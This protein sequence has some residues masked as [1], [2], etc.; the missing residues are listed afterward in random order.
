MKN[1]PWG[2]LFLDSPVQAFPGSRYLLHPSITHRTLR[3]LLFSI[4]YLA[5]FEVRGGWRKEPFFDSRTTGVM[6]VLCVLLRYHF[7]PFTSWRNLKKDPSSSSL[8]FAM[9]S[10]NKVK[11]IYYWAFFSCPFSFRPLT[12][13]FNEFDL[14]T[15]STF[16]RLVAKS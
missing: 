1:R 4:L 6:Y 16:P 9:I 11:N 13:L 15:G 10:E 7:L 8:R 3:S 2:F 12:F 14:I 5:S